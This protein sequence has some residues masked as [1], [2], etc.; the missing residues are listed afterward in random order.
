[1]KLE[2]DRGD[3]KPGRAGVLYYSLG[4]TDVDENVQA[5]IIAVGEATFRE[6]VGENTSRQT[7]YPPK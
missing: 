4:F 2:L 6:T 5:A 7:I 1:M 3:L